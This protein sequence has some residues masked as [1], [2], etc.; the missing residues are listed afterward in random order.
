MKGKKIVVAG[1][2]ALMISVLALSSIKEI[3]AM[4]VAV[5]MPSWDGVKAASY[6]K[7]YACTPNANYK[8]YT[9]GGDCTNFAS[10]CVFAGNKLKDSNGGNE[11]RKNGNIIETSTSWY[12]YGDAEKFVASTSWIRCSG[13]HAFANYWEK[14]SIGT[15]SQLYNVRKN[16]KLGDVIQIVDPSGTIQH[17]VIVVEIKN[18][19]IY[20][21]SH[22]SDYANKPLVKI[23]VSATDRWGKC[24]YKMFHF[25]D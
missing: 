7:K 2:G 5:E 9:S 19:E 16:A 1:L 22:T 13:R 17:S 14:Y 6:A 12:Y 4:P 3:S 18:G 21:A 15:F 24:R 25:H 10:Q 8:Y 20:C 11:P 23:D